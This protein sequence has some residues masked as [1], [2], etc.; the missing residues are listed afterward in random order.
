MSAARK[1]MLL[2]EILQHP[3]RGTRVFLR[4]REDQRT[5]KDFGHAGIV[6]SFYRATGQGIF[7][8]TQIHPTLTCLGTQVVKLVGD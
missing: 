3:C 5:G 7:H 6:R 2:G 8:N 1:V 4:K